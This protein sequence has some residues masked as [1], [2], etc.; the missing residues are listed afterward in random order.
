[1]L[2]KAICLQLFII[3]FFSACKTIPTNTGPISQTI[4]K[5][6]TIGVDE[7]YQTF[8]SRSAKTR[9]SPIKCTKSKNCPC[10]P[11]VIKLD[12]NSSQ[13]SLLF[14]PII[15]ESFY[16]NEYKDLSIEWKV[17]DT[18]IQNIDSILSIKIMEGTT[19][20]KI[21][22]RIYSKDNMKV[23]SKDIEFAVE[24]VNDDIKKDFE[25]IDGKFHLFNTPELISFEG[26]RYNESFPI[27]DSTVVSDSIVVLKAHIPE[28]IG[29]FIA[30][31][32]P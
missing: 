16:Q 15:S 22:C 27:S 21:N 7:I 31:I 2:I 6:D 24:T 28:P 8:G 19:T 20:Y 32:L 9:S 25:I 5:A 11:F 18:L 13:T 10:P 1:M 23:S 30:I 17:N 3:V 4:P 29:G 12:Q 14:K 26:C